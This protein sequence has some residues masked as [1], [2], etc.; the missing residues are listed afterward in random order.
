VYWN[1]A[2]DIVVVDETGN[3]ASNI[4]NHPSQSSAFSTRPHWSPARDHIV[5]ESN[6]AHVDRSQLVITAATGGAWRAVGPEAADARWASWSPDGQ[7]IAFSYQGRLHTMNT[8]GTNIRRIAEPPTEEWPSSDIMSTWSPDSQTLIFVREYAEPRKP[9]PPDPGGPDDERFIGS[10]LYRVAADGTGLTRLTPGT[11]AFD[12]D[13]DWSPDGS[14]IVF[15]AATGDSDVA[16]EVVLMR[17]D[18]SGH[19]PLFAPGS[20]GRGCTHPHWSPGGTQLAFVCGVTKGNHFDGELFIS[21]ADGTGLTRVTRT[22][23][24][25]AVHDLDW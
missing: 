21:A 13:P 17:P 19:R 1:G 22:P 10:Y 18:G 7:T 6:V 9:L 11:N 16:Q 2:Y 14:A 3:V 24:A 23:Q 20:R 12:I 15:N 4:T 25:N 8:D 5:F